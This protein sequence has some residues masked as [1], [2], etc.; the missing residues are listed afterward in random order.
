MSGKI[1]INKEAAKLSQPKFALELELNPVTIDLNKDQ[2]HDLVMATEYFS[3]LSLRS[4]FDS[5]RPSSLTRSNVKAWWIFAANAILVDFRRRTQC[6]SWKFIQARRDLRLKYISTFME[7]LSGADVTLKLRD[8]EVSLDVKDIIQY[9]KL[10]H[11]KHSAAASIKQSTSSL[12][13]WFS[14]FF[15]PPPMPKTFDMETEKRR[16]YDMIDSDDNFD[17]VISETTVDATAK[18]TL[19]HLTLSLLEPGASQSLVMCVDLGG[20]SI[21]YS[22]RPA[23]KSIQI[24]TLLRELHLRAPN[25]SGQ[26]LDIIHTGTDQQE[27]AMMVVFETNPISNIPGVEPS[28]AL[29][30]KSTQFNMDLTVDPIVRFIQFIKLP[31]VSMDATMNN[32]SE[33]LSQLRNTSRSGLR[34]VI[35]HRKVSLINMVTP[36]MLAFIYLTRNDIAN[37]ISHCIFRLLIST[38]TYALR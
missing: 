35:E 18:L 25:Q 8:L 29:D 32:F 17:E 16:F 34:Y 24:I 4:K 30:I 7:K 13:G 37:E 11:A 2:Y 14:S 33:K 36:D 5:L 6:W 19:P 21:Q 3:W 26:V 22:R 15:T 27:P 20:Y 10:A 28:V 23:A 12:T 1:T 31:E 38:L 9:R